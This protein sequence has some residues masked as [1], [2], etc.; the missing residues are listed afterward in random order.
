MI[1]THPR[2]VC[3]GL[4]LLAVCAAPARGQGQITA[5]T[6]VTLID[7]TDATPVPN[8]T[9]LVRDGRVVAAGPS[10]RVSIPAG[11]RRTALDGKVVIPGLINAHGHVNT[12][13][14]L[15]TYAA[16]GVTTVVSLGGEPASVFA[17]RA[18]QNTASLNHARVYLAGPVLTPT[19]PAEARAQV[20]NVAA[21][22]VDIVKIRVDDNL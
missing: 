1:R 10:S 12:P 21:Q 9:L 5:F 20:A 8:A 2:R 3:S 16:Y 14:D 15:S 6:G 17:S 4:A 7:G 22:Q 18:Q 13:A 19:T 11:A